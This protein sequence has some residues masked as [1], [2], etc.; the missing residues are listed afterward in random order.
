M[1][2]S[3][4][5]GI[6]I[7]IALAAGA[8]AAEVSTLISNAFKTSVEALAPQFE[9]T[10]GHRLRNVFGSTD[11]LMNRI[12]KGEAF[13]F[14]ILGD[15]AMADLVRQGKVQA[16]KS[17]VVARSGIGVAMPRGAPSPDLGSTEAFRRTLVEARSISYN[18]EGLTGAW[19]KVLF[20]RLDV[21]DL[22]QAKFRN[23]PWAELVATGE[24]DIG[25]SQASEILP[26]AGAQFAGMLPPD[27]QFYT[28]FTAGIAASAREPDAAAALLDFLGSPEAAKT[29]KA[30]GLFARE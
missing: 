3:L 27:I 10:T 14:A 24:A 30:R 20:Q 1:S 18:V 8:R 11:P 23:G 19:L 7:V 22:V 17:A 25:I 29:M 6:L 4:A 9:K 13:D 12:L 2:G 16:S 21:T 15:A 26:V 5:A 28:V